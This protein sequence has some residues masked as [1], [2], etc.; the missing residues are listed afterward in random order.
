MKLVKIYLYYLISLHLNYLLFIFEPGVNTFDFL[1]NVFS[2]MHQN[3][4]RELVAEINDVMSL[5]T[6][7]HVLNAT[8][9]T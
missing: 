4:A 3:E 9:S 7:P 5:T 2:R 1:G 8:L 6:N